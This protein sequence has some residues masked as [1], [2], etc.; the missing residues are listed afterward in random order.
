MDIRHFE[1]ADVKDAARLAY[2]Y[3]SKELS[4]S[5]EPIKRVIYKYM[6]GYYDKS[7]TLSFS[8]TDNGEFKGFLLAFRKDDRMNS[9]D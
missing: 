9:M 3:W 4:G 1:D 7:R 2:E 5:G 6:V 8:I